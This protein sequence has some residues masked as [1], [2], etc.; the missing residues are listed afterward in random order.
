MAIPISSP[1]TSHGFEVGANLG[2]DEFGGRVSAFYNR[3]KNFIDERF[4]RDPTGIYPIGITEAI[5]RANV[6]IQGSR[7]RATK[8]SAM[9]SHVR[10]ALAYA[11]GRDLDT[12]RGAGSVAPLK[13]VLNVG[14]PATAKPGEPMSSWTRPMDRFP[15]K[16][17]NTFKAPGYGIV[18]VTAGGSRS[19][20]RLR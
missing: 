11:Y 10:T 12:R 2:D 19:S 8:S 9:A 6:S 13:G 4:S 16:S 17:T 14:Y 15:D 5:N 20:C 1:E 7:Y 18:D 3:Y